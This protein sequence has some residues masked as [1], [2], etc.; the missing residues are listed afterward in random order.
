MGYMDRLQQIG[1][2]LDNLSA[3]PPGGNMPGSFGVP[4][5]PPSTQPLNINESVQVKLLASPT[6][7]NQN[8]NFEAGISPWTAANGASLSQSSVWSYQGTYSA[9][10]TGN[11]ATANP[12]IQSEQTIPV[13]PS[14]TYTASAECYSPQGW[15]DT[16]VDINWF[17]AGG[18]FIT[19]TVGGATN[20]PANT[21]T[22]TLVS[23][24]GTS[25]SNAAYAQIIVQMGGTP[26]STVEMFAD[27]DQLNPGSSP[28]NGLGSGVAMITPGQASTGQGQAI[29]GT[30]AARNSGLTWTPS[31]VS[32]GV[33]TNVN[34]AS[35]TLYQTFGIQAYGASDQVAQTDKG[36]SGD[37]AGMPGQ[38]LRPG[39]WI[40]VVWANGDPNS[41]ATM[42]VQ[43][44]IQPPGSGS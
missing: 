11:G 16:V 12:Q 7:L 4:S 30:G 18:S 17:T 29:G 14:T 37:T 8:Y 36:S 9:L 26:A 40:I 21:P 28:S 25:P 43:G 34:E 39:D 22:G 38:T 24:T 35:A 23:V 15:A 6:I 33:S 42:R 27:L 1:Q 10:F 13:S 41:I 5:S 2:V 19:T 20:V 3:P 31:S 44:T 32:V